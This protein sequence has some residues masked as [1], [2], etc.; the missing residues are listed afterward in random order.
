VRATHKLG[1]LSEG[2]D[3]IAKALCGGAALFAVAALWLFVRAPKGSADRHFA[4]F[5]ILLSTGVFF[6][7]LPIALG[8]AKP[9][10]TGSFVLGGIFLAATAVVLSRTKRLRKNWVAGSPQNQPPRP[11][12]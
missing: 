11:S 12:A 6:G 3:V 5:Q 9:V 4:K 2:I 7:N 8:S 1:R 10:S